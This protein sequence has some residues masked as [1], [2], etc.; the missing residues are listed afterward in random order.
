MKPLKALFSLIPG[1]RKLADSYSHR[2]RARYFARL[3]D[4]E[5][6]FTHYYQVNKWKDSESV[7]GVGS[8]LENTQA[9]RRELPDFLESYNIKTILDAPCGDYNWFQEISRHGSVDYTGGDIVKPLVEKNQASFGNRSTRFVHLDI[10]RDALPPA[11]LWF[12]RDCLIHLS[13]DDI[14]SAIRNFISS[15]IDYLLTTVHSECVVNEEIQTG[16]FRL[17]NLE[18]PPF[19]FPSPSETLDDSA[20]GLPK[21]AMALWSR[22]ELESALSL[23]EYFLA[24]AS[25]NP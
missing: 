14:R 18:L 1:G 15:E 12:C 20:D 23:N 25:V 17:L 10:V 16:E 24:G 13:F 7:S 9:I 3:G 21:R 4:S 11:D 22:K 19:R 2:K 5:Q 8:T 6:I